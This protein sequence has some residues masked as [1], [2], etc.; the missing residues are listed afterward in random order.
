MEALNHGGCITADRIE[1]MKVLDRNGAVLAESS[2]Y[3]SCKVIASGDLHRVEANLYGYAKCS[4]DRRQALSCGKSW[5]EKVRAG[6]TITLLAFPFHLAVR[7][8]A[9][10]TP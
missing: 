8:S 2:G 4:V 6:E 7:K 1:S 9:C 5:P 10:N 3:A